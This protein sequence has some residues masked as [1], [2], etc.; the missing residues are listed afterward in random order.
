MAARLLRLPPPMRLLRTLLQLC[1]LALL[2]A[3]QA[4]ASRPAASAAAAGADSE[5]VDTFTSAR[6]RALLQVRCLPSLSSRFA[7]FGSRALLQVRRLPCWR[8]GVRTPHLHSFILRL[9][10]FTVEHR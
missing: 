1:A 5:H 4:A 9:L 6:T 7:F 3:P 8:A 2:S 10:S